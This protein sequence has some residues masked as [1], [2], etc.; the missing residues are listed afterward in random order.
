MLLRKLRRVRNLA[1]KAIVQIQSEYIRNTRVFGQPFQITLES[2]NVCNLKCPLCPTTH[3]EKR[4]PSGMLRYENAKTIIDR[5][6]YCVFLILSNWGEPFLNKE[7]FKIISYAKSKDIEVRLESN[8]TLFNEDKCRDLVRSRLDTLVIA[9]DGVSQEAYEK[10][11][12]GGKV[13]DVL[14]N[15]RTLRKVQKEMNDHHTEVVWKFVINRHN[16]HEVDRAREIAA[17][18]GMTFEAVTIWTPE[19]QKEEWLP[20]RKDGDS[21]RNLVGGPQR[22]HHLWQDVSVNFNGDLFPCCSE[23][24][25][26]DKV[27]NLLE[28]PFE[29]A[30]NSKEYQERRKLNKKGPVDCTMCHGDKD[31]NWYKVWVDTYT[32]ETQRDKEKIVAAPPPSESPEPVEPS[33]R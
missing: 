5:F 13:E 3:R 22:C 19:D 30:W 14:E 29:N 28:E 4:I 23:F 7:I 10:Y 16:D 31:T 25:P 15:I 17:D 21:E 26:S 2:G 6:P 9:L 24:T 1:N 11:R 20:R 8:F 18:L 12:V 32:G 33:G 27:A